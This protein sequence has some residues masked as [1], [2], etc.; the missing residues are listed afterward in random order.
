MQ[1]MIK[2]NIIIEVKKEDI[3]KAGKL[4]FI[5]YNGYKSV[6]AEAVLDE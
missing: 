5:L 1:K 6:N 2:E 3:E 4:G